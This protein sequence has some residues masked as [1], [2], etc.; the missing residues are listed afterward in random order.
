MSQYFIA[1]SSATKGAYVT[2]AVT[3]VNQLPTAT[4][5]LAVHIVGEQSIYCW[6]MFQVRFFFT[7]FIFTISCLAVII[8]SDTSFLYMA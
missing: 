7:F 1:D 3:M 2:I 6:I 4:A 5:H 8:V